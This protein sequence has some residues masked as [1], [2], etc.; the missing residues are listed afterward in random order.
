MF[1][2]ACGKKNVQ[3]GLK[4]VHA[5]RLRA[6]GLARVDGQYAAAHGLGHVGARI[7]RHYEKGGEPHAHDIVEQIGY[8]VKDE[9]G[10][11]HH[12]RAPE[13][14]HINGQKRVCD[15][16]RDFFRRSVVLLHGYGLHY[17]H[18]KADQAAEKGADEGDEQ[19]GARSLGKRRAI[20]LQEK[21][22][23]VKK[24]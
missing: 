2:R 12:G 24:A 15:F 18:K 20:I 21:Q 19:R 3:H 10:L 5:D 7:Y 6:L 13:N 9:H 1:L 22:Q 17:A 23:P 14:L 4:M 8:A 16:Q 11:N